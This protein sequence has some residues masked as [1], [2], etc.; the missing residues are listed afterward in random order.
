MPLPSDIAADASPEDPAT[1]VWLAR[2]AWG[3]VAATTALI[4]LGALVRANGAGLACPDWPLCFGQVIPEFDIK[5]AFE[6]S[7]RVLA[8]SVGLCFL[9]LCGF[10]WRQP[11]LREPLRPWLLV[12][13]LL[14]AV[15][16][17]LGALTVWQLLASW[18]VTSHLVVGNAVNAGFATIAWRLSRPGS[19]DEAPS[20]ASTRLR[21]AIA[22]VAILLIAQLALGGQVSSRFA[23]LACDE[24]P[25][26]HA[27]VWF[28]D[29]V[30]PRGLHL[31]H[32]LTGYALV[33][34][35]LVAATLARGAGRLSALTAAAASIGLLQV[36]VGVANV[37]LRVPIE[38]TGLHSLLAAVLVLLTTVC[39]H[40]AFATG[41]RFARAG[42]L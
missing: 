22:V 11:E 18:T 35:L 28:P 14:L 20:L 8:G 1:A 23:G 7:H 4:V 31:L 17:T 36:A 38:V 21:T 19:R 3:L 40:E 32:R 41:P 29:F 34:A 12:A 5:V 24:W 6:Y 25:A 37:L 39:L 10:V 16:V 13:G 33:A 42:A 27:G 30:G 15:Q 9:A 2:A 26:C